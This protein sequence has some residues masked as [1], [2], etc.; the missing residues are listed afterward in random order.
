MEREGIPAV[1][2]LRNPHAGTILDSWKYH[3]PPHMSNRPQGGWLLKTRAG[4]AVWEG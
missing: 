3:P 1:N 4:R 2:F